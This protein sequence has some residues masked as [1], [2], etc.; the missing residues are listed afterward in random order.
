MISIDMESASTG[1][2]EV[3]PKFRNISRT[4]DIA[5]ILEEMR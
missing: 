3:S 2:V 4:L 1:E 5:Q